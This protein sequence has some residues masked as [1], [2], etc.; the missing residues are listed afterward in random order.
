MLLAQRRHAPV[1]GE[2]AG[3]CH[4]HPQLASH[5]TNAVLKALEEGHDI[6]VVFAPSTILS[7]IAILQRVMLTTS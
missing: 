2:V 3:V 7:V 1:E 6:I 4:P 5:A